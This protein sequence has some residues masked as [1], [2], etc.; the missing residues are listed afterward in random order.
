MNS[1]RLVIAGSLTL[2]VALLG[3]TP[4]AGVEYRRLSELEP[5]GGF[6]HPTGIAVNQETGNVYVDDG[7]E[8]DAI[9]VFGVDGDAPAG[10]VP[11]LIPGF[12]FGGPEPAEVA[13]DS[14]CYLQHKTGEECE[15]LDPSNGDL[16]VADV[17]HDNKAPPRGAIEK[18]RFNQF[19]QEY[20]QETL[21][22]FTEPNGVAVDPHG[23]VYVAVYGSEAIFVFNSE[24]NKV[25]EIKQKVIEHPAFIAVDSLNDVY[26][27]NYAGGVAKIQISE[28]NEVVSEA[29]LDESSEA[30]A[31]AVDTGNNVF[32]DQESSISEYDPA[33][34]VIAE[35]GAGDFSESKGI[36]VNDETEEVYV[37]NPG[38]NNVIV[39]APLLPVVTGATSNVQATS[40]T[41]EGTVNPQGTAVET[42]TFAYGPS[43][44]Y[45]STQA[46]ATNPGTGETPVGVTATVSAL[47]PNETYHYRLFAT[48][49]KGTL[50]GHDQRFTT[51]PAL[52]SIDQSP[53]ASA[54]TRTGATVTGGALNP[55]HS[56]TYY[57][58]EYGADESYGSKTSPVSAGGGLGD[59]AL[60]RQVIG[61]L[62]AGTL[63]HYR[64]VAVNLAGTT[65]GSDETFTTAT[66]TPPR[67]IT[68]GASNITEATATISATI[69]TEG[70]VSIYG[71]E[72]GTSTAYGPPSGSGAVG[73]GANEATVSVSL[74]G[75][76]PNTTYHYRI[77]ATNSDGTSYGEDQTF[78]TPGFPGQLTPPPVLPLIATPTL[79]FPTGSE[80][81]TSKPKG[82]T[83]PK[84]RKKA[85]R[86]EKSGK[87]GR[88]KKKKKK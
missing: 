73:A 31:I 52:A 43:A 48:N 77:T 83:K 19:A 46:C 76:Q 63:Y 16:Y 71:F 72:V 30:K 45:G 70:L 65:V 14:A 74:Q 9:D 5:S 22:A 85:R 39:F 78:T 17:A 82:K 61:E 36:A 51:A 56:Q 42:C 13:I 87:K 11:A 57:H 27:G 41:L 44:S 64:L 2:A 80:A 38:A 35:F 8:A 21:A 79:T 62:Q 23:N 81:N 33:G 34:V 49:S 47:V 88:S 7:G 55:E 66:G 69:N 1:P 68:G 3:A 60:A 29:M 67:V 6:S 15:A 37:S 59:T 25:A 26:V 86:K 18:L 12:S 84:A 4:A 24:G 32:V 28:E 20:E 54:T 58:L 75:L 10:G 40:A 50:K 53:S